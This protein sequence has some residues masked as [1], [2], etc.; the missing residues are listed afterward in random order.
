MATWQK[1]ITSGSAAELAHV[2]ASTGISAVSGS[3]GD[4][5]A[6]GTILAAKLDATAVSDGLAAAIVAEIDNDEIPI[7]KLAE[8][9]VTVTAGTGLTGGGAITLGGSATVNV[10][11]GD[12][13]T[14][15]ANDIAITAAQ[16]TITS[17]LKADLVIGEDSQTKIDFE[18]ANEI[19][20]DADNAEVVNVRAGGIEV[21]GDVTASAGIH[22]AAVISGSGFTT[23]LGTVSGLSGS[24]GDVSAS[25]T[26]LANKL[27]AAG[28]SD[29]LAAAIVAEIDND[30]IPIAKLA[31]DAVTV[32]AGTGL[33]GGGSITLGGSATV[34]VIGGD[35]IT[36]NANDI[37]I[38]AA[39]TTITSILATDL[40]IGEDSQTKI[41]FE[42]ANEIH[43]DANNA[44]V[45]NVRAGG[46]EVTGDVTAS[47]GIHAAAVI[48]GSGFTT[49]LGTV[50]AFSGAFSSISASGNTFATIA[51]ATQGTIDHDSLANFVAN[52]HIDHSGVSVV[53]G[54]GLTG[55][56]TI[57]ANRTLNVIGGDGIT[58]NANDMA[59]TAAQTTITSI[60]NASLEVGRDNDNSIKF[61][62]DNQI[63]FRIAATDNVHTMNAKGF[64]TGDV[65]ASGGVTASFIQTP[66]S[67]AAALGPGTGSFGHITG[68]FKGDGSGLTGIAAASVDID[69]LTAFS[70]VPHATQDEFLISD[71]GTELRA[72]MTMVANGAFALVTGDI[73]IAEGG[74][75]TLGTVGANHI[76]EISNLTAGEGAQ[77][78]N[79]NSVTISN[80]QW[81]YLGALDQ[82]VQTDSNVQFNNVNVDGNL[83]VAGTASFEE[84]AN[85]NVK[86]RFISLASGSAAGGDGG[87]VVNQALGNVPSGSAFG[88]EAGTAD[89]WAVQANFVPTGSAMVPDA[90]MGIV[91]FSTNAP[92]GNPQYGG[93]NYGYGNIHVDTDDGEIYI[94]A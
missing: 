24:F 13:I 83:V 10:I 14:A 39:Q 7:A 11:G 92:T 89:R 45:V 69:T 76:D 38:T 30:E 47:A 72:T 77:L 71:N 84:T 3:F 66:L 68:S 73:G 65:T 51:T 91:T 61:G 54:T 78:E 86:D 36:A 42:T 63:G 23:P 19:H 79:I 32:T 35:G 28:V 82:A 52:E 87:I 90:Y 18:T 64:I 88:Y 75:A 67:P 56:G 21:T 40:V 5:S 85:L 6:S 44:E 60:K 33:T 59:I 12:G 49:P 17:I 37:A 94:F 22:A 48:S 26:I 25:G 50:T 74:A 53:A 8:D 31:E 46:I 4:V 93:A 34:N 70:G 29:T 57:A 2:T 41:D 58:A 55:G 43:L 27:D 80:T 15:N 81:G 62:E 9:A 20:L 16:T 1:V